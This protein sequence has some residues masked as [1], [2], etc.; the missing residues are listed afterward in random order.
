MV[1]EQLETEVGVAM[2]GVTF[3][4]DVHILEDECGMTRQKAYSDVER[5]LAE[6]EFRHVQYSV[7]VC[8]SQEQS[9]LHLLQAMESL[10]SKEWFRAAVSRIITFKVDDASDA[11]SYFKD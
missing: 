7:Y 6:H 8:A 5:T 9:M 2:L 1:I 10:K 4:L 11:L 3:D